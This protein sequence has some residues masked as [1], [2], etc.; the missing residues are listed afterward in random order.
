MRPATNS[1]AALRYAGAER[2]LVNMSKRPWN[3]HIGTCVTDINFCPFAARAA[4]F[5]DEQY[6]DVD[7]HL[8]QVQRT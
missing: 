7:T 2:Q 3:K 5:T 1:G 8:S 4:A 6:A